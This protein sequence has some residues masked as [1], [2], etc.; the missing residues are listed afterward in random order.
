M[1][2]TGTLRHSDRRIHP[3]GPTRYDTLSAAVRLTPIASDVPVTARRSFFICPRRRAALD[4]VE[5]RTGSVDKWPSQM[6]SISGCVQCGSRFDGAAAWPALIVCES[7]VAG[8]KPPLDFYA[9]QDFVRRHGGLLFGGSATPTSAKKITRRGDAQQ[10]FSAPTDLRAR[11]LE[12]AASR[13]RR[14][15]TWSD[16]AP[17]RATGGGL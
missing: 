8:V 2:R 10:C 1:T 13:C 3:S 6:Q 7:P 4:E 12:S 11:K 16:E 17:S 9:E 5:L 15:G 14:A